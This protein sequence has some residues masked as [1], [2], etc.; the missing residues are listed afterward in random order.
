VGQEGSRA[1]SRAR[2]QSVRALFSWCFEASKEGLA[3]ITG[4]GPAQMFAITAFD[5][6]YF[7]FKPGVIREPEPEPRPEPVITR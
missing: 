6:D 1:I 5:V 2:T 4:G 7:A 3:A